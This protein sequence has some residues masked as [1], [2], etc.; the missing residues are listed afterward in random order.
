MYND[1]NDCCTIEQV[2]IRAKE[3]EEKRKKDEK[4]NNNIDKIANLN[5]EQLN[6]H[7][8]LIKKQNE[9]IEKLEYNNRIQNDQ[10]FMLSKILSD[11]TLSTKLEQQVLQLLK[12]Q[13]E[14]KHPIW[15]QIKMTGKDSIVNII[16]E[17][18]L[19]AIRS[20]LKSNGINL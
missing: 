16:T 19:N 5:L 14:P 18:A 1:Y 10:L 15:E 20:I 17:T 13:Y 9:I 2:K 11:N 4:L 7:K 6:S 8:E 12:E 3:L